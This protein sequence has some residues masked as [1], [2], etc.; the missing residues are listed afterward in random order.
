MASDF[1]TDRWS[2][3]VGSVVV[4]IDVLTN[5]AGYFVINCREPYILVVHA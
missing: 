4:A 3:F 1:K 5:N 2:C